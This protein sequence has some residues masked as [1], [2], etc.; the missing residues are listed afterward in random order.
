MQRVGSV[1][2]LDGGRVGGIDLLAH[3]ILVCLKLKA[4]MVGG[5]AASSEFRGFSHSSRPFAPATAHLNLTGPHLP[6]SAS[7]F[8]Q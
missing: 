1:W 4:P 8:L 3:E 7:A 2:E 6:P 5:E